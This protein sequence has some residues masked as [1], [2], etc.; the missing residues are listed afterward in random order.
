MSVTHDQDA[1]GYVVGPHR[2]VLEFPDVVHVHYGGDVEL[3]HFLAFD[4]L[5]LRIPPP[6]L[7]YLLRDARH[8]GLITPETRKHIATNDEGR[9]FA[10]VATYG[11]SFHTKT[12]FANVT[13][14]LRTMRSRGTPV[15]FF[16]TESEAR[17]WIA[18]HRAFRA[19]I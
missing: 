14:A 18:E 4:E 7:L 1:E 17:A 19:S 9:R 2:L 8:G 10:A 11:S 15:E 6:T 16:D 3:A 12:V 13:R 5:T